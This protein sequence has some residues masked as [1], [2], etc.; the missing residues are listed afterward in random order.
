M[1]KML[2]AY[3]KCGCRISALLDASDTEGAASFRADLA[4]YE[5]LEEERESIAAHFCPEHGPLQD[6]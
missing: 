5:I 2:V 4:E 3:D 1:S 6:A